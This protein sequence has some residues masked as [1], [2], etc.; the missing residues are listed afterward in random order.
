[1]SDLPDSGERR[2]AITGSVRDRAVGKG[3][4]DLL[5]L[6]EI[7]DFLGESDCGVIRLI[8]RFVWSGKEE[9]LFLAIKMFYLLAYDNQYQALLELSKRY[10]DG[11]VKYDER[12][13][14]KGQPLSWYI[15]SGVRHYLEFLGDKK[16]ES[17]DQ[18]VGWNLFGA[19]WTLRNHPELNDLP[20]RQGKN[21][22]PYNPGGNKKEKAIMQAYQSGD[23]RIYKVVNLGNSWRTLYQ[24]PF[25]PA[26]CTSVNIFFADR[27]TEE[28]AQ[29][30]L[31][32]IAKERE[33]RKIAPH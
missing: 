5:P 7:A 28:E 20:N 21:T 19:I 26:W 18:A 22:F 13:W 11:A 15:D 4:C 24:E 8:H 2:K 32:A 1:M 14:E 23:L 6:L 30:D 10:E 16:E 12:N 3:R 17:H 33:W 27:E 31:D 9:H 29:A 25:E